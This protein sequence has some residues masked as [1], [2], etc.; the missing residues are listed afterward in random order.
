MY[1]LLYSEPDQISPYTG[2]ELLST[3]VRELVIQANDVG[4]GYNTITHNATFAQEVLNWWP[5]KLTFASDDVGESTVIG[6]RI[7]TELDVA[8]NPLGYALRA[9]IGY[10]QSHYMWDAVAVYYAVCGLDDM[11]DWK[12]PPGGHVSLNGSA[13]ATWHDGNGTGADLQNSIAF[14]VPNTTFAARLED[15]LLWEPGNHVPRDRTWC[16]TR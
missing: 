6:K 3:K 8:T 4:Y 12:Y 13:Y 15:T 9:N 2:A 5:G 10:N 1:S 11:F 14:G 16:K 7:T